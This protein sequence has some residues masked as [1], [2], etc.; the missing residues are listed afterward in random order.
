MVQQEWGVSK[1][2]L[3]EG[4]GVLEASGNNYI[5]EDNVRGC[6]QKVL[7]NYMEKVYLLK[8]ISYWLKP[9]LSNYLP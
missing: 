1:A 3:Y 8:L 6:L 9:F 2:W 4:F 7:F 5:Y